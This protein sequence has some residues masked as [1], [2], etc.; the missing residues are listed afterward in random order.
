MSLLDSLKKFFGSGENKEQISEQP[1]E[2]AAEEQATEEIQTS[3]QEEK[4]IEQQ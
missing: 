3:E 4:K 2:P 1:Q